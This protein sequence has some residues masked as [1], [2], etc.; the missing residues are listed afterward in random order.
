MPECTFG[1]NYTLGCNCNQEACV[2]KLC[3]QCVWTTIINLSQ[4]Q[5]ITAKQEQHIREHFGQ[6]RPR[7][8]HPWRM[9]IG[10][11]EV[12]RGTKLLQSEGDETSPSCVQWVSSV[13][14][15]QY[16]CS[17]FTLEGCIAA[18]SLISLGSIFWA[19]RRTQG[20]WV[21]RWSF[22]R[23]WA[24][25]QCL[26]LLAPASNSSP[27]CTLLWRLTPLS[28]CTFPFPKWCS[29]KFCFYEKNSRA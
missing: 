14:C 21:F 27:M 16:G 2:N 29:D 28:P 19:G 1:K 15:H 7:V 18:L 6:N 22:D 17:S 9:F 10:G 25:T 26:C 20:R 13:S 4:P 12:R 23:L 11:V 8:K 5:K 3:S 24:G